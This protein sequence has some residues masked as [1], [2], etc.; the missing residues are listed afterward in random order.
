MSQVVEPSEYELYTRGCA[1]FA[2]FSQGSIT[3][4]L[5]ETIF[6][7]FYTKLGGP[8]QFMSNLWL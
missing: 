2:G 4:K 1:E 8:E 6:Q 3:P 5:V 7:C